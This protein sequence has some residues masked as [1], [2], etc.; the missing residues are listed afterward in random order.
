M[1]LLINTSSLPISSFLLSLIVFFFFFLFYF[2]SRAINTFTVPQTVSIVSFA[3]FFVHGLVD[4]DY[5]RWIAM[6]TMVVV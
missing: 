3:A 5:G 4:D 6:T 2:F 1:C